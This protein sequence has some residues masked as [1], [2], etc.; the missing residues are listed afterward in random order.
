MSSLKQF[1]SKK[2]F[3][4]TLFVGGKKDSRSIIPFVVQQFT[5]RT[6]LIRNVIYKCFSSQIGGSIFFKGVAASHDLFLHH[7]D[8]KRGGVLSP[9]WLNNRGG[10]GWLK[11]S[12]RGGGGGCRNSLLIRQWITCNWLWTFSK[13]RIFDH[14]KLCLRGKGATGVDRKKIHGWNYLNSDAN[15]N[16][17]R[18]GFFLHFIII[19]GQ[20]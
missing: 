9:K 7:A 20:L 2:C 12:N 4:I 19:A 1:W 8:R 13:D 18:M 5:P 3:G 11:F 17:W 16:V 15:L 6:F 14:G 10:G